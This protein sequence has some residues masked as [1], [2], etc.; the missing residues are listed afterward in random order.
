MGGSNYA[1]AR[2]HACFHTEGRS[3][4]HSS[5]FMHAFGRLICMCRFG[6]HTLAAPYGLA[7]EKLLFITHGVML[8]QAPAAAARP[9]QEHLQELPLQ[10]AS[11]SR[12]TS[13]GGSTICA[14]VYL[15]AHEK[16]SMPYQELLRARMRGPISLQSY[17]GK[18]G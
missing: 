16:A 4:E 14:K 5:D 3:R 1:H 6:W 2:L 10:A 11:A 12:Y 18:A 8:P 17:R 13:A 9:R 7:P 15:M